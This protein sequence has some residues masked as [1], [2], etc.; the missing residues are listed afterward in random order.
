MTI[1]SNNLLNGEER[2]ANRI[3][4][5]NCDFVADRGVD[6]VICT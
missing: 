1:S 6:C 2:E 3:G 4:N 5:S